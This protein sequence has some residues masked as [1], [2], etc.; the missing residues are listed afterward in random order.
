MMKTTCFKFSA[1]A[2]AAL[3]AACTNLAPRYDTPAAPLP[4]AW[5][6]A[7]SAPAG[8]A[9]SAE[10]GWR[11][12]VTDDRLR[13]VIDLALADNRD[14]RIAVLNIE[15]ARASYRITAAS[16]WPTVNASAGMSAS[17]TPAEASNTGLV[18]HTRQYSVELGAAAYELDLFGRVRN[19]KDAA[20]ESFLN[21]E[22]AQRST[23]LALVAEVANAW[24]TLAADQAQLELA[25]ET[26]KSQQDSYTMTARQRELGAASGLTL[27]QAQ[28][29]VETAR[30]NV[31]AYESQVKQDRNALDLLAGAPVPESLLPQPAGDGTA[32]VLFSV[33]EGL[34]SSVLQQRPDVLAAE[35]L[36]KAAYAD[37][38]A[39][40]AAF[41]PRISLT[42]AAGT[43]SRSLTDLFKGGAWSFAPSITLPI[44]DAGANQ[45]NLRSAEVTRDIR[46]ATYEKTLQTAFREVADALAVRSSLDERL[47]A[48]QALVDANAK[49]LELSTARFRG[50]ASSYL[51]VLDAQRSLYAAQQL[52]IA[53]KLAEQS[54]R[55][56]LFKALGGGWRD[57]TAAS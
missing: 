47:A 49:S 5:P 55:I 17:R 24:L 28:T 29:S 52:L 50:G 11:D 15:Q 12:V 41:F 33:P 3:L 32:A 16:Q 4:K 56:T 45:A 37:I 40:R 13:G 21:T 48:Q 25:R 8:Q 20:L 54:N 2:A 44:F 51:E 43:A 39:A 14:L 23:R 30:G 18:T 22:E 42:A 6:Q 1:M 26:L 19:L 31:A 27:A 46:V 53:L 38:G 35:H 9:F 7:A 36:L 10:L 57:G 34:P